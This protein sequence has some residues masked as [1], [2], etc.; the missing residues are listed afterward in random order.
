M[1]K[2][3]AIYIIRFLL[4]LLFIYA[5][6]EKLFLPYDPSVFKANSADAAPLF[7]E[8]YNLL[9]NAGYLYFV[10]FFQ[11]LCGVLLIFKRTYV[12]GSIMLIP[13]IM[14]LLATHVF[15]SKN[16]FYILFDSTVLLLTIVLLFSGYKKWQPIISKTNQWI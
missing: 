7:F 2:K 3:I 4:A 10:G 12:L 13:L 1:I 5:G 6:I 16:S 11:L 15:I 14:C 8:F 9:Q